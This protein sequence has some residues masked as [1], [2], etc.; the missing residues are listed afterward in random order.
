V[1]TKKR[2][3]II[4]YE[5]RIVYGEGWAAWYRAASAWTCVVRRAV[6]WLHVGGSRLHGYTK[7]KEEH[8]KVQA[9]PG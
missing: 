1:R 4:I 3:V 6:L 7:K 5:R 9:Q 2:R 8:E